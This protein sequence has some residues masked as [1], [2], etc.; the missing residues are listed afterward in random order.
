MVQSSERD[1]FFST[2]LGHSRSCVS[3][4]DITLKNSESK[5]KVIMEIT[6]LHLQPFDLKNGTF[7]E[8]KYIWKINDTCHIYFDI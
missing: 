5:D 7:G 1:T 4:H 6:K 3:E 8:G 2:K